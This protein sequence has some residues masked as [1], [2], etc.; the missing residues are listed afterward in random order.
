[1]TSLIVFGPNKTFSFIYCGQIA[2]FKKMTNIRYFNTFNDDF[3]W[4]TYF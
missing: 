4:I 1:M 2:V 3:T